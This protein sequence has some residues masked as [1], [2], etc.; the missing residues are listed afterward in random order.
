MNFLETRFLQKSEFLNCNGR[1]H[2]EQR[3][4]NRISLDV[5]LSADC[6]IR[7]WSAGFGNPARAILCTFCSRRIA[8]SG[9]GQRDLAI[10]QEQYCER[11]AL[12]GLP[13]PVLVSGIWQSR[14]SN[15]V[16]VLLSA[17]CQIPLE[18]FNTPISQISQHPQNK[19]P[20]VKNHQ[21]L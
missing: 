18:P 4:G 14:K 8:K 17:D 2:Q 12:G 1:A 21:G 6:Q 15:T 3:T 20:V 13:N 11:S 16:N 5:L 7:C 19:N 10:P 9:A